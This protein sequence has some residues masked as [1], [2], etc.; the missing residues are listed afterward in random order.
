[1]TTKHIGWFMTLGEDAEKRFAYLEGTRDPREAH[2]NGKPY[3]KAIITEEETL[4]PVVRQSAGKPDNGQTVVAYSDDTKLW[5]VCT[6]LEKDD[7]PF[8]VQGEEHFA[9]S[10]VTLWMPL[11][12][13]ITGG[14]K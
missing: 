4:V 9:L 13:P 5:T 8:R 7:F 2:D 6:F 3:Y 10:N 1:M 12:Q 11:P 14:E